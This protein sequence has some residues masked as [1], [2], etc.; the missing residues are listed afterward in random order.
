MRHFR[1]VIAVASSLAALTGA[2]Q[3]DPVTLAYFVDPTPS[4]P[5]LYF[6]EATLKPDETVDFRAF[7]RI[8]QEESGDCAAPRA[9]FASQGVSLGDIAPV[10]LSP[11]AAPLEE[12]L[13]STTSMLVISARAK[14]TELTD[15]QLG[16]HIVFLTSLQESLIQ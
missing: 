3:A 7:W 4:P 14:Q 1:T 12:M 16:C 11:D 13:D 10:N 2:A 8:S 9:E 6:G 15:T 5:A